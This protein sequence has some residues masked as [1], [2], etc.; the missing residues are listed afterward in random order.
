M[1][2]TLCSPCPPPALAGICISQ[3]WAH[4]VRDQDSPLRC[5]PRLAAPPAGPGH[6]PCH[7]TA[8][9]EGAWAEQSCAVAF[10]TPGP[11]PRAVV[12][13]PSSRREAT[14]HSL[15][16]DSQRPA[17]LPWHTHSQPCPRNTV[18]RPGHQG[19]TCVTTAWP[20]HPDKAGQQ[21]TLAVPTLRSP[22]CPG[23]FHA[24]ATNPCQPFLPHSP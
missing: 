15:L 20:G 16:G 17:G 22:A 8:C 6:P 14:D 23:H 19:P 9:R 4:G 18:P 21:P 5:G 24:T 1:I 2:S 13:L 12:A 11:E 10:C 3:A 7:P